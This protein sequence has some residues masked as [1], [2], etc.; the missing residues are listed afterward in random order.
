MLGSSP[1]IVNL[2]SIPI[3]VYSG[4]IFWSVVV[5]EII[6]A[7]LSP[8]REMTSNSCKDG[9]LL[10]V[11]GDVKSKPSEDGRV[12]VFKRFLLTSLEIISSSCIEGNDSAM[13]S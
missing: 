11:V 6:D 13:V 8:G 12:F 2:S 4:E 5:W 1:A 3:P 7:F 10:S 9:K